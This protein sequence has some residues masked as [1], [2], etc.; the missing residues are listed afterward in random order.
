MNVHQMMRLVAIPD[1]KGGYQFDDNP[2]DVEAIL[3]F[4]LGYMSGPMFSET[5]EE[6][7]AREERHE[8][9]AKRVSA[10]AVHA[11]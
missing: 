5:V 10:S 7:D 4:T 3:G 6:R 11:A 2:N 9:H 8:R 1:G